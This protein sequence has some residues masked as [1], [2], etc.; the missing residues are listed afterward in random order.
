LNMLKTEDTVDGVW[1]QDMQL[2][3]CMQ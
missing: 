2:L 3:S 1:L